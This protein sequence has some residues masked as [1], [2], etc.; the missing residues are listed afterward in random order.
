MAL[1]TVVNSD[2]LVS[3]TDQA[4]TFE[5]YGGY[6]ND[7]ETMVTG[8]AG[9]DTYHLNGAFYYPSELVIVEDAGAAGGIDTVLLDNAGVQWT[10]VMAANVESLVLV[11]GDLGGTLIG[12]ALDNTI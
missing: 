4:D 8:G 10:F 3:G 9:N 12:N 11:A 6:V 2:A 1:I 5:I 7:A